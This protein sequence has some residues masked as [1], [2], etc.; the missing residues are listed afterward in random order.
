M[1]QRACLVASVLLLPG[2]CSPSDMEG[3]PGASAS[4]DC[5]PEVGVRDVLTLAPTACVFRVETPGQVIVVGLSA[6]TVNGHD[7]FLQ[8]C[9]RSSVAYVLERMNGRTSAMEVFRAFCEGI[10][11]PPVLVPAESTVVLNVPIPVDPTGRG[12]GA[13]DER[14]LPGIFRVV[15]FGGDDPVVVRRGMGSRFVSDPFELR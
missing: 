2:A 9:G 10:D 14:Y 15:V 11:F 4:V 5:L 12:L 6:S 7:H 8:P 1:L 3:E 13:L